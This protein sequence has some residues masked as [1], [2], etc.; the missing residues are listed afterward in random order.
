M[1]AS[2]W[3][4][5]HR[6]RLSPEDATAFRGDKFKTLNN[7]F[8]VSLEGAPGGQDTVRIVP[9]VEVLED[10]YWR[11]GEM[12]RSIRSRLLAVRGEYRHH[13][14]G[15]LTGLRLN[16]HHLRGSGLI[17]WR[18]RRE[19]Q[20]ELSPFFRREFG[21]FQ[22]NAS[23][24]LFAHSQLDT[25]IGAQ[26]SLGWWVSPTFKLEWHGN[27]SYR[28][29]PLLWRSIEDTLIQP[30]ASNR[31]LR[32]TSLAIAGMY[33]AGTL[34][35]RGGLFYAEMAD[36]PVLN[37]TDGEWRLRRWVNRGGWLQAAVS[38]GPFTLTEAF[39][40]NQ[41]YR[42]VLAPRID[43]ITTV[44]LRTSLFKQ[45]LKLKGALIWRTIGSRRLIDFNRLLSLYTPGN[46]TAPAAHVLDGRIQAHIGDAY[47]FFVWENLL[48]T[49]FQI[50]RGT[51][52][53]FR[54]FRL[55]VDWVVFD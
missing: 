48:S 15:M 27:Q 10:N 6:Y 16:L 9:T 23:G 24:T 52:E 7:L 3:Q 28:A 39:T 13:G 36:Y 14:P 34:A 51:A 31:P 33:T 55:G 22:L 29:T 54:L 53:Q 45:K 50:I 11:A 20:L 8:W 18:T 37:A 32:A 2:F 17:H 41:N 38:R 44:S 1:T 30:V 5:W 4:L 12:Q 42:Q 19:V 49:D 43:N 21:S 25:R 47:L 35:L 26:L 40:W 46:Q